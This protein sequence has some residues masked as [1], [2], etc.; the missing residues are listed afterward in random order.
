MLL[1]KN[2]LGILVLYSLV[3]SFFIKQRDFTL[4]GETFLSNF[5]KEKVNGVSDSCNKK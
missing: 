5:L 4:T 1:L 2:A 3:S